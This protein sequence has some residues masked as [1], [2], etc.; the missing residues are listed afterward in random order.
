MIELFWNGLQM[1][2]GS[3]LHTTG[4]PCLISRMIEF[5]LDN[6]CLASL[7]FGTGLS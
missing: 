5:A 2:D 3:Y 1:R 4:R 7:W 6:P